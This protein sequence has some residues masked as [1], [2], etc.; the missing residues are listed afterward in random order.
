MWM[1]ASPATMPLFA[2]FAENDSCV[3]A[4]VHTTLA[5]IYGPCGRYKYEN[6]RTLCTT[7]GYVLRPRRFDRP[8]EKSKPDPDIVQA[9]LE[10]LGLPAAQ[11]L[12]SATRLMIS[13]LLTRLGFR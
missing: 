5:A 4:A 8:L 10:A 2:R 3:Y 11:A 13:R 12:M 1:V 6:H 9:A 7:I